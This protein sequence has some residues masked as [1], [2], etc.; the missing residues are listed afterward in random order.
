MLLIINSALST[1]PI[2]TAFVKYKNFYPA[3]N[4]HQNFYKMNPGRYNSY[5]KGCGRLDRLKEIWN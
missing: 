4:Y 5:F 3:E 1:P 2:K